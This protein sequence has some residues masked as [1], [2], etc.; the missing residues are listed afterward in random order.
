MVDSLVVTVIAHTALVKSHHNVDLAFWSI[1]VF[2]LLAE[3]GDVISN[4]SGWPILVH[5]VLQFGIVDNRW[6]LSKA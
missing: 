3:F 4:K 1:R 6:S 5:A 2:F